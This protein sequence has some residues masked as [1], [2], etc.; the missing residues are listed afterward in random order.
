MIYPRPVG[1]LVVKTK[2]KFKS[3]ESLTYHRI[4]TKTESFR[5]NDTQEDHK[6]TQALRKVGTAKGMLSARGPEVKQ[7]QVGLSFQLHI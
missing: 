1:F 2:L 5:S 3:E 6:D 7:N 4:K